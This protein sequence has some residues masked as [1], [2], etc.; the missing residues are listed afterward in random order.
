MSVS[1]GSFAVKSRPY[2]RVRVSGVVSS[3]PHNPFAVVNVTG[4]YV[5]QLAVSDTSSGNFAADVLVDPY[6]VSTL[7]ATA[8]NTDGTSSQVSASVST[9]TLSGSLSQAIV[10]NGDNTWTITLTYSGT[11]TVDLDVQHRGV[12]TSVDLPEI[13]GVTALEANADG[14]ASFTWTLNLPS[15]YSSVTGKQIALSFTDSW[16]YPHT[17]ACSL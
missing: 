11:W 14:A 1:I 7:Y 6:Q 10:H 5:N 3:S 12:F 13:N 17:L 2:R 15:S 4:N 9:P 16:G 8:T